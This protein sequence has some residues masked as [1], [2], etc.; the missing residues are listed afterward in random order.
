MII[1]R[2]FELEMSTLPVVTRPE[3]GGNSPSRREL[4]WK[5]G[6]FFLD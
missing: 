2:G 6:A 3:W 4:E 5:W 1:G